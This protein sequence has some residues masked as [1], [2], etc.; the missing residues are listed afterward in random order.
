MVSK[1]AHFKY[2]VHRYTV[3]R[4]RYWLWGKRGDGSSRPTR[5]LLPENEAQ[6]VARVES[7]RYGGQSV[8]QVLKLFLEV[9]SDT[10]AG[11][12]MLNPADPHP[13]RLIC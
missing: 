10:E 1:F 5:V 8:S 13:P 4:Q 9:V 11:R 3:E 6:R 7:H 12:C 2:N